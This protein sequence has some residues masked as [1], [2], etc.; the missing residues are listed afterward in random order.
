M[1]GT[2]LGGLNFETHMLLLASMAILCDFHQDICHQRGAGVRGSRYDAVFLGFCKY[3]LRA[4]AMKRFSL[5]LG[6]R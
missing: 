5:Q 1:A 3:I 2:I 4:S 6:M